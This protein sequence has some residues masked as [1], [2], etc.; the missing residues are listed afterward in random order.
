MKPA[1]PL[2]K[3]IRT[4]MALGPPGARCHHP[5]RGP[6]ATP[7]PVAQRNRHAAWPP[8]MPD[9]KF[10]PTARAFRKWLEANASRAS[11]LLVGY[12]KV[13]TGKPSMSWPESVDEALC[14]GWIDGV[15]KRIDD[16]SYQIRFTPRRPTSIWSAV[17]IAKFEALQA[18]GRM[19]PAGVEAFKNRTE[20]KSVVYAYEQ[21]SPAELSPTELREFKRNKVA[22]RFFESSP[23]S[24][25]KVVLHWVCGARKPEIRQR[26]FT[27]LLEACAAGQRLR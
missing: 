9:P 21:E 23:P 25:R 15:R 19:T 8:Q 11:E 1:K 3:R 22:W 10:F 26:R 2:M 18:E 17:N 20:A 16:E 12:H 13:A 14:F 6:S 4:G 5:L 7:A 27:Q 24:H